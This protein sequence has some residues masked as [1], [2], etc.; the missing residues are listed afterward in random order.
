MAKI[1]IVDLKAAFETGDKPT[2]A[3]FVNL[4]DTLEDATSVAT[5]ADQATTYTKTEVDTLLAS[6]GGSIT[7]NGTVQTVSFTAVKNTSY[8]IQ[9]AITVTLPSSPAI[10][11]VV[12]VLPIDGVAGA[13]L[14]R[15]GNLIMGL[16]EDMTIGI[17]NTPVKLRYSN[18]T[19][20]WR[21][22]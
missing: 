16:A 1:S 10:N 17:A 20:G 4:I 12:E 3:D 15:N 18:S 14:G 19:Y 7:M 8:F 6:A 9:G 22:A 13:I 11:D 5:K 21:I 2:G